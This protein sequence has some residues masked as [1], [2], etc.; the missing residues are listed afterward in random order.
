MFQGRSEAIILLKSAFIFLVPA[1]KTAL[2]KSPPMT[3]LL[4]TIFWK[5]IPMPN[6][7]VTPNS[8][9]LLED[10]LLSTSPLLKIRLSNLFN[11]ISI[12]ASSDVPLVKLNYPAIQKLFPVFGQK[13]HPK[14]CYLKVKKLIETND[15][16]LTEDLSE[17][18]LFFVIDETELSYII[19]YKN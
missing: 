14:L 8:L 15:R 13:A 2:L 1:R 12:F 17:K 11:P 16:K 9:S 4:D 6:H 3:L 18:L 19:S 10:V 7:T 5:T